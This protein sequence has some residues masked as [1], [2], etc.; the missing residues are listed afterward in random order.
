MA[1]T[2]AN[3]EVK[4]L[5]TAEDLKSGRIWWDGDRDNVVSR[6]TENARL[7]A[8]SFINDRY[9]T[10]KQQ[11]YNMR[12]RMAAWDKQYK[13]EW[14][15]PVENDERIF[16]PKTREEINAVKAFI[17]SM[18]SNL[19]PI[20]K[21]EPMASDTIW[22]KVEE[23]LTRAKLNEALFNAYFKDY[24]RAIDDVIPLWLSHFLKYSLACYKVSYLETEHSA[25]LRLDVVDRAFLFFD[26]RAN[27]VEDSGW[28]F[29]EYYLPKSEVIRRVEIGDWHLKP[30]DREVIQ[31]V[32][33]TPS[34][35]VNLERYFGQNYERTNIEEDRFVVCRDYWQFKRDGLDHLL[36][37]VIGGSEDYIDG[38]LVRYG[39]NPFPYKGNP[40]VTAS[41]NPDERP[42]GQGLA[43]LQEPFQKVIN[44]FL[45]LRLDDVRKN[46][47]KTNF[48][49][50][51]MVDDQTRQDIEDGNSY[52]RL[53]KEW[54]EW[55]ES[56]PGAKVEDFMGSLPYGTSTGELLSADLPFMLAQGQ[57]SANMPDVFRG[58][59]PNPGTTLGQTQEQLTR[60]AG[61]FRPVIRQVMRALEKVAE[62]CTSYFRSEEFFPQERILRVTGKNEYL[63]L[64]ENGNWNRSSDDTLFKSVTAD[65]M[66]VDLIFDAVSGSDAQASKSLLLQNTEFIFHSMGQRPE[67]FAMLE[68]K[69]DFAELFIQSM[70]AMG[71]D[72]NGITL[73]EEQ[74]AQKIEEKR[75][76]QQDLLAQQQQQQQ[77]ELLM[78]QAMEQMKAELEI[79]KEQNKQFAMAQKQM[80]VDDN[81]TA[82]QIATDRH[83]ID[84]SND[85]KLEQI[86]EQGD[87]DRNTA[88]ITEIVK[89][90]VQ[91]ALM[92]LEAKLEKEAAKAGVKA[93]VGE[94][95]NNIQ[96]PETS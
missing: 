60:T 42:D 57:Q 29:E 53:A 20:V 1:R 10:A 88:T 16:L 3:K 96:E 63:K 22:T 83:K 64:F 73:T 27:K 40:F 13:G 59:A 49:L 6:M 33:G 24:W 35:Q 74:Q 41:F 15:E 31:T 78:Q 46:V 43:E 9:E 2:R 32:E 75:Q 85:A 84:E 65:E 58:L 39:P 18:M 95:G 48:V 4:R 26:P 77:Q 51:Q 76:Q 44:T 72:I 87:Q 5:I 19:N 62:I 54:S 89:G 71:V 67:L 23:D 55:I 52:V 12:D 34:N 93:S 7:E 38:S 21:M 79:V 86:M 68:N 11:T 8:I 25:D 91:K 47:R 69:I 80:S 66:D 50:E 90:E 56:N 45:N 81:K 17:I 82:G 28:I 36:A 30:G 14:Q 70:N 94:Q 92:E 37:T 61:Q